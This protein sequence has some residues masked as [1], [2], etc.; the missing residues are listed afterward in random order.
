M[1][2]DEY[3]KLEEMTDEEI[4]AFFR[5]KKAN[6]R[7][8]MAPLFVYLILTTYSNN[9]RHLRQREILDYLSRRPY[10]VVIERKALGRII[11]NLTDSQLMI[12]SDEK[13]TWFMQEAA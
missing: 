13:G 6:S 3:D 12:Y 5:P 2:I 4:D 8:S 7:K 9:E 1:T 11:H 10:E